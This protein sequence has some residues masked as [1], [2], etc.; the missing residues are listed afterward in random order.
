MSKPEGWDADIPDDIL[1][2]AK[3]I[4]IIFMSLIAAGLTEREAA[5]IVGAMMKL[6]E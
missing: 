3:G 6:N 4:R 5:L 1:E 2:A